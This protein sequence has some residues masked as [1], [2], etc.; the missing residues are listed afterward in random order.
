MRPI[1][2][3][4]TLS[5]IFERI[6]L[7]QIPSILNTHNNQFGY[8]RHTSC[9]HALFCFKETVINYIDNGQ[10]CIAVSLDAVKAFDRV[11]REALFHKLLKANVKT[12]IIFLIFNYYN[13]LKAKIKIE[14]KLTDPFVIKRGVKQGGVLS[15]FLFNF[16][17]NDL[18]ELCYNSG[19]GA[20][21]GNI[22]MN[23]IGFCDDITLLS[24]CFKE[25]QLLLNICENYG[26][27]WSIDFNTSKCLFIVFGTQ[28]FNNEQLFLNNQPLVFTPNFKYLG[29]CFNYR[30]NMSQFFIDKFK[31]V[32]KSFFSL[33]MMGFRAGGI[34]PRLQANV[35]K[36][37]CLSKILYGLEIMHIKKSALKTINIGQNSILKFFLGLNKSCHTSEVLSQLKIFNIYQLNIYMK[38]IFLKNLKHS[39]ISL[40][41]YEHISSVKRKK[42]SLSFINDINEICLKM[43]TTKEN[44]LLNAQMFASTFKSNCFTNEDNVQNE[45]IDICLNNYYDFKFRRQLNFILFY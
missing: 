2:I 38:I 23:I 5:Q 7:N 3:S 43:Q 31:Q 22:L 39:K 40:Q 30:L 42:Q 10:M 18:I 16:F 20:H 25:M 36:S 33:H 15:P 41:I 44:L 45:L 17:I 13:S 21:I 11:W 14:G 19:L 9:S 1:S 26:F 35:Y 6:I 24:P 34:N 32:R 27:K 4:N 8:K 12:D 37:F 28:R 29:L